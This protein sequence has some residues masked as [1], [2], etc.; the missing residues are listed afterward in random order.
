MARHIRLTSLL[1][2]LFVCRPS[3]L[4]AQTAV[5]STQ[6][7]SASIITLGQSIVPL[8]GPW[9]F[10]IGDS[11]MD[12]ETGNPLWAEPRFDDSQWETVD[13]T[14]QPGIVDPFLADP[15]YVQGWTA[16]GHP[17]YWGYAWYRIRVLAAAE[18]GERLAV[19]TN[20][21]D[22]GY[23][24]FAQGELVGSMGRFRDGKLP[25]VYFPQPAM[26]V[27]PQ[28]PTVARTGPNG[29]EL[30]APAT[31]VLAF[32]VWMSP[33]R[34]SHHPFTGGFH[35]A[36]LLGESGSIATQAH[37]EWLELVRHY[38]FSGFLSGVFLLLTTVAASL[39]LFDR[40][41]RVYL[42]VAGALMLAMLHE[43]VFSLANWTRLVSVREFFLALEVFASPLAIGVWATMWWKWFQLRRPRWMLKAIAAL[44]VLDMV[45]ELL[46]E[47]LLYGMPH[48]PG[49]VF[50]AASG[51]VRLVLLV[52]LAFI[53]GKGIRV[54]GKE[55]WLVLPAVVLMAFEQFQGELISLHMHGTF[56]A[57]GSVVF[58]SEAADLVLSAAI[59]LLLLR[60]LLLSIRRQR[61]MA[62]DVKQAQEVQQV[63]LPEQR[64]HHPGFVIESEYRPAREVGGDF[65]Q[66]IPNETD[67]SLLI[68][69]GD[70]TGKGLKAG[71]L[72]ALLVGA[73]R[74]T[75][76]WTREP[77]AILKALN[78]RL[79]GRGD[80]Q[81]TCLALRIDRDGSVALANA[82]HLPPYLNGEPLAMEGALPLG[83][84]ATA[85]PSVM[86]FKLQAN[87]KLVL[88]SDGIAE[89][90]DATGNLFGFERVRELLRASGTAAEVAHAA[91]IFGQE[92]DISVITV[93]RSVATEL[94]PA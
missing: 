94:A 71:M 18:P 5:P 26:H 20:G 11:P 69:A 72:V 83:I 19:V 82:G 6:P 68:V 44:T 27:L 81:A 46:G 38:A 9:K 35:Y 32:R 77:V 3:L 60:R 45:F 48:S 55:G 62:L 52:L 8:Y 84:I 13:L 91:Q 86:N 41:D 64:I 76:D 28:S 15:A 89:A 54:Q 1:F 61:Q 42:W 49:V 17:G 79:I 58:Y 50:H 14:P 56:Y 87:D 36:P 57:F 22:D 80:A 93:A 53:V 29:N 39:M 67:N 78:Q 51:A 24:L 63:I 7:E 90:T 70:V 21:V 43:F 66:I 33:I 37:L 23:Q 88:V 30:A 92:D 59:A 85:E 4:S 75:V 47:N 31:Q 73:I 34:L 74:S 12:P 40:S 25:V 10:H 2:T 16:K 65:F